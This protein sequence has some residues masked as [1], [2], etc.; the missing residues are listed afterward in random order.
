MPTIQR[1]IRANFLTTTQGFGDALF[2]EY[3]F[4]LLN[5]QLALG[6]R[7]VETIAREHRD[8]TESVIFVMEKYDASDPNNVPN[9]G[10]G[11]NGNNCCC[12]HGHGHGQ[13]Q[14]HGHCDDDD[15]GDNGDDNG[16]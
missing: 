6:Y 1:V 8:H 10:N 14:G 5:A 3:D 16:D 4:P 11:G 9:N 12:C 15:N 7:V 13:G 2:K